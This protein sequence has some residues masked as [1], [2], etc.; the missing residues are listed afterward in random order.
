MCSLIL[1]PFVYSVC[2]VCYRVYILYN[3]GHTSKADTFFSFDFLGFLVFLPCGFTLLTLDIPD[4]WVSL[5][6]RDPSETSRF[7]M[8]RRRQVLFLILFFSSWTGGQVPEGGGQT[9]ADSIP[10]Q[11]G[12]ESWTGTLGIVCKCVWVQEDN[13]SLIDPGL[14]TVS[15]YFG[16]LQYI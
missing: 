13:K 9:S 8:G 11:D 6:K 7:Q 5:W 16:S 15:C 1:P 12:W 14:L 10:K 2:T 4:C 3:S